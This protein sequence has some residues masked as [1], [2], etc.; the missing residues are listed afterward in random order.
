MNATIEQLART[1]KRLQREQ[2]DERSLSYVFRHDDAIT[3]VLRRLPSTCALW[4]A[5]RRYDE[6]RSAYETTFEQHQ[7]WRAE[8]TRLSEHLHEVK[9]EY[10]PDTIDYDALGRARL[11]AEVLAIRVSDPHGVLAELKDV[12]NRT[13]EAWGQVW[14]NYL[15][16]KQREQQI[17]G[18]DFVPSVQG[19]DPKAA[20]LQQIRERIRQFEAPSASL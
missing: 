15:E 13:G 20:A 18:A 7:R 5:F 14:N 8:L 10:D 6:A 11:K 16:Q 3:A 2:V 19:Y 12:L 9:Q 1:A 17:A 4:R